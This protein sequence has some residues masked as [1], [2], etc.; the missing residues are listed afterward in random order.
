[1]SL[2][3]RP[4]PG[5]VM[6]GSVMHTSVAAVRVVDVAP[7]HPPGIGAAEVPARALL[8]RATVAATYGATG[9]RVKRRPRRHEARHRIKGSG[10]RA[11]RPYRRYGSWRR[12]GCPP[13]TLSRREGGTAYERPAHREFPGRPTGPLVGAGLPANG[14]LRRPRRFAS[15]LAPTGGYNRRSR[16]SRRKRRLYPTKLR[17][18]EPTRRYQPSTR[19]KSRSL[20]G[21]EMST[22]GS[23]IMPMERR[24][25]ATTMSR[26][27]KGM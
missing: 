20:N 22:G 15:K 7:R 4:Q 24:T 16:I 8:R 26:I 18:R 13:P 17:T 14:R 2:I 5:Q 12:T 21:R 27:R 25:L 1:V 19:T 23:I 9:E 3:S 10:H 11:R 6:V